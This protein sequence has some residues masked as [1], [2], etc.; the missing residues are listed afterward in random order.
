MWSVAGSL[1]DTMHTLLPGRGMQGAT[2]C[3]LGVVFPKIPWHVFLSHFFLLDDIESK[4]TGSFKSIDLGPLRPWKSWLPKNKSTR[5]LWVTWPEV[6]LH[7][8]WLYL[9]WSAWRLWWNLHH[10]WCRGEL[11]REGSPGRWKR[12]N[13]LHVDHDGRPKGSTGFKFLFFFHVFGC[14]RSTIFR[15]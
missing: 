8:G 14:W 7:H 11:K 6:W 12:Q 3:I 15:I 9:D 2:Q 1:L 4:A 13:V 5:K 10:V